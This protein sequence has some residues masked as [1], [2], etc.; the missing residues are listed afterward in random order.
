MSRAS[1]FRLTLRPLTPGDLPFLGALYAGTRAREL[2]QAGWGADL[3]AAFLRGQFE[4]QH[5]SYR[6][7][8][9]GASFDVI[10]A[11][12]K[13]VG[14][15]YVARLPE[16]IRVVEIT[17]APECRGRGWGAALLRKVFAEADRAGLPVRLC[18][19]AQN[20]AR[21]L[22]RRLGFQERERKG[23]YLQMERPAGAKEG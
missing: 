16:E 9:P 6:Q 8:Y 14:R 3:Q 18:V 2:S 4:A 13:A 21:R 11:G 17:L 5:R 7:Q 23:F 15:L 20:R 12:G 10:L 22:Y 19:D 1:N